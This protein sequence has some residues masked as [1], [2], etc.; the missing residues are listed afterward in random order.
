MTTYDGM[1][2]RLLCGTFFGDAVGSRF[3][4]RLYGYKIMVISVLGLVDLGLRLLLGGPSLYI[5]L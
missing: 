1:N 5:A 3:S 2:V 4:V